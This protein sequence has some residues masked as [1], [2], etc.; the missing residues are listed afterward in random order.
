MV[1]DLIS[2]PA[3]TPRRTRLSLKRSAA[4]SKVNFEADLRKLVLTCLPLRPAAAARRAELEGM[5][6]KRLLIVYYNWLNRLVHPH[7]RRVYRSSAFVS[8]LERS[9]HGPTIRCMLGKIASGQTIMPHLS[10]SIRSGWEPGGKA[11]NDDLMASRF[12]MDA[13]LAG[14]RF[15]HRPKYKAVPM[16]NS[17]DFG[18]GIEEITTELVVGVI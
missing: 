12:Q 8:A 9:T 17:N 14:V 6:T 15:P 5:S 11:S 10:R 2:I 7:A 16:S 1:D 13:S 3:M 18:L 4:A